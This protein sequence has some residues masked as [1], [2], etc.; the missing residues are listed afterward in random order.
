MFSCS[1]CFRRALTALLRDVPPPT[2]SVFS[3]KPNPKT[4]PHGARHHATVQSLRK[5]HHLRVL[6]DT[7]QSNDPIPLKRK[8]LRKGPSASTR[9]NNRARERNGSILD[10]EPSAS[11]TGDPR[12]GESKE[13]YALQFLKDPLK[14]ASTVLDRLRGG[15]VSGALALVRASDREMTSSENIV[16]WNHVM[17]YEMSYENVK[18]A[19]K[20]YNEVSGLSNGNQNDGQILVAELRN[21]LAMQRC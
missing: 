20:V 21:F 19:L 12:S 1:A 11:T 5:G 4:L 3:R 10:L 9:R 15:D 13:K 6:R 17:D 7:L 16:S 2:T 8:T 14:L 18:G